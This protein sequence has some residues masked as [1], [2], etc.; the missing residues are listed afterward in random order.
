MSHRIKGHSSSPFYDLDFANQ[1]TPRPRT[2]KLRRMPITKRTIE[3]WTC[4]RCGR[5][6]EFPDEEGRLAPERGWLRLDLTRS[7]TKEPYLFGKNE[8]ILCPTDVDKLRLWLQT[9]STPASLTYNDG[10]TVRYAQVE[11][12]RTG[13]ADHDQSFENRE[14][15]KEYANGRPPWDE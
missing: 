1:T 11:N 4:D 10:E 13:D 3:Q 12:G 9:N 8:Q 15:A 2:R 5:K 7:L 6:E 14:L